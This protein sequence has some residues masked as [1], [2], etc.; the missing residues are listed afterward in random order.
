MI[1]MINDDDSYSNHHEIFD[2]KDDNDDNSD[3]Q[4]MMIRK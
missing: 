2:D 1:T 4:T 3:R